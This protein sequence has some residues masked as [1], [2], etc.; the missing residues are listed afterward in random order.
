MLSATV[1][2][3]AE[4]TKQFPDLPA[5]IVQASP[6]FAD[7]VELSFHDDGLASF[8]V[9]R[10]AMEITHLAVDYR[11]RESLMWVQACTLVDGVTVSLI[12]FGMVPTP[13]PA[14]GAAS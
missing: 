7:Q 13:A 3:L 8:E 6:H 11:T 10:S 2:V 1:V 5:P 12:G 9:W 4:L 14:E